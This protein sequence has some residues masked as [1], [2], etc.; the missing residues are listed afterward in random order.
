MIRGCK[1][2]ELRGSL[3]QVVPSV[4]VSADL[5]LGSLGGRRFGKSFKVPAAT[6]ESFYFF[7]ASTIFVLHGF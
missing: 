2:L 1:W 5:D 7:Y 6:A 4:A 3:G